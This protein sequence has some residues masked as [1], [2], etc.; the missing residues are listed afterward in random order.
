VRACTEASS[1]GK[2]FTMTN[3]KGVYERRDELPHPFPTW[4][5][6]ELEQLIQQICFEKLLVRDGKKFLREPGVS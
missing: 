5:R 3:S 2:P 1:A 4:T 6:T